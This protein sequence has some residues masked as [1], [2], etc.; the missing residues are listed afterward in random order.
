M[1]LDVLLTTNTHI[2]VYNHT[3]IFCYCIL[4][5]ITHTKPGEMR[6]ESEAYQR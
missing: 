5:C 6:V 4:L 2:Y 1:N 3:Y